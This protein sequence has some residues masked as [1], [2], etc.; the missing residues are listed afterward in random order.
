MPE[1][2]D[3][4]YAFAQIEVELSQL[5]QDVPASLTFMI[6]NTPVATY[7]MDYRDGRAQVFYVEIPLEYLEEGYNAFDITGY[8]RLYDDDG[9]IDDFSGAN[10]ICIRDSSFIQVGYDA[11]NPDRRIS[12]YPYPFLSSLNED[13]SNTEI[14][15]SD[16]CDPAE[17]AAALMLRADLASET[18]LEDAITLARL[19]DSAAQKRQRLIVSLKDNLSAQYQAAAERALEGE[20]LSDRAMIHFLEEGGANV[21][22]ITSDSGEALMEAVR[23][24]MDESRVSQEKSDLAFVSQDA[25]AAIRARVTRAREIQAARFADTPGIHSNAQ[26]T[27]RLLARWARPTPEAMSILEHAMTRYDMSARAY[28]RILKVARTIADLDTSTDILPHHI[29][30]AISYRSLD[31]S[32]WGLK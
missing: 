5:I 3:S 10:W 26:M 12:A 9:C 30:E 11:R 8:V 23:L 14:L 27:P 32:T 1:Y 4:R 18:K 28:D 2:W 15:V 25:S 13:G 20:S 7:K 29:T 31:R 17:L 16:A 21:L 19:S 24:L 6:N 22:L